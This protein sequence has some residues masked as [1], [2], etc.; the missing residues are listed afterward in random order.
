MVE[1]GANKDQADGF[2]PKLYLRKEIDGV[3]T[4]DRGID[5]DRRRLKIGR[6]LAVGGKDPLVRGEDGGILDAGFGAQRQQR[7]RGGI[8]IGK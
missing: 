2:A 6:I 5:G 8:L 3:F 7:F 4:K 1:I